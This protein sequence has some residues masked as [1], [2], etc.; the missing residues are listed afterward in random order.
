MLPIL[1]IVVSR[2]GKLN[3]SLSAFVL[4]NLVSRDGSD[5][6]VQRHPAHSPHSRVESGAYSWD[7]SRFPRRSPLLYNAN[8]HRI[9]PEFI[10]SRIAYR[11]RSLPRVRRHRSP[12]GSSSNGYRLFG[13]HH[14]PINVY[15]CVCCH[16]IYTGRQTCGHTS[17][18]HTGFVYLPSAVL[19]LIFLARRIQP[20]LLLVDREVEFCVPTK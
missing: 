12:Q 2:T 20:S 19:A 16:P 6:P 1:L 17:R 13:N 11:W 10:R 15:V 7:P 8:R 3:V 14:G 5:R 9:S 18:G 4:E